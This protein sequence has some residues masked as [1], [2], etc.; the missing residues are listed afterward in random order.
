MIFVISLLA[1]NAIY[2]VKGNEA[3]V[4]I[5]FDPKTFM[6]PVCSKLLAEAM[7]TYCTTSNIEAAIYYAI[8]IRAKAKSKRSSKNSFRFSRKF[9]N[10]ELFQSH[11]VHFNRDF[12]NIPYTINFSNDVYSDEGLDL[13]DQVFDELF[14]HH[15]KRSRPLT[16]EC[17]VQKCTIYTLVTYCPD[18]SRILKEIRN[19]KLNLK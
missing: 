5:D 11:T 10:F 2:L 19:R 7:R 12:P 14:Q 17:C 13:N 6:K 18:Y 15:T 8:D 4:D 1:I 16:N 9:A 3:F